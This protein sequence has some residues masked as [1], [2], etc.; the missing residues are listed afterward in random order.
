LEEKM[1]ERPW[2]A[3]YDDGIPQHIDYPEV[4]LFAL[5]EEPLENT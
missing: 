4:P 1:N 3:H 5:L 2:L